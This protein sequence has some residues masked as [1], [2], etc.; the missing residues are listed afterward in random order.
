MIAVIV[1]DQ[2][3]LYPARIDT[4]RSQALRDLF[5]TDP[6]IDEQLRSPRTHIDA[7]SAAAACQRTKFHFNKSSLHYFFQ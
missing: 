7:I 6:G 2:D 5:T 1:C 4:E 3:T